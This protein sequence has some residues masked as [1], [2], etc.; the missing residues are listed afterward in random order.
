VEHAVG[1]LL[2]FR[3]R[4]S[5]TPPFARVNLS[6][7]A[8]VRLTRHGFGLSRFGHDNMVLSLPHM[9]ARIVPFSTPTCVILPVEKFSISAM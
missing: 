3:V 1:D 9:G 2:G 5:G 8:S 7:A 4:H 6:H